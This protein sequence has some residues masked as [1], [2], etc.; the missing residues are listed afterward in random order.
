MSY[1]IKYIKNKNIVCIRGDGYLKK[2]DYMKASIELV[3]LLKK[4]DSQRLFVDDRSLHN[5][6]SV[7]DLYNLAK[8]FHEIGLPV[9]CK[10]AILIGENTPN[11]KDI[12]FFET[13]CSNRGYNMRIFKTKNEVIKW[14]T[15][16]TKK[17]TKEKY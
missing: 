16:N 11:T 15:V 6:A 7:I 10:I 3:D 9:N 14:L 2:E 5:K 17:I 1:T 4:Y 12:V 13:V 8:F